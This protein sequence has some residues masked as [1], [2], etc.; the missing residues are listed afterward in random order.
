MGGIT[1]LSGAWCSRLNRMC[2]N[3]EEVVRGVCYH[4]VAEVQRQEN[5]CPRFVWYKIWRLT[6]GKRER[7]W[8]LL[9]AVLPEEEHMLATNRGWGRSGIGCVQMDDATRER[10]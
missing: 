2:H 7:M 8:C 10:A 1:T 5:M 4:A 9:Q 3:Q 6:A